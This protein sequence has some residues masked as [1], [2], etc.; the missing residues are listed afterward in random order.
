MR[1]LAAE[2]DAAQALAAA[3][4]A[5]PY[6][7]VE[8]WAEGAGWRRASLLVS[9]PAVLAGW[10]THARAVIA[11]RAGIAAADVAER[12]EAWDQA[13]GTHASVVTMGLGLDST[14]AHLDYL[15]QVAGAL[16]AIGTVMPDQR[17]S[18]Q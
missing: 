5:G 15:G 16:K 8:P 17:S 14:E 12:V 13:G 6:F 18:S 7:A 3:G 11:G 1:R 9:D 10:V 2:V 4:G